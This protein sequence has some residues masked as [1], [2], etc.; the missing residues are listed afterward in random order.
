MDLPKNI[1]SGVLLFVGKTTRPFL[2]GKEFL[3]QEGHTIH[4]SEQEAKEETMNM[5]LYM[6]P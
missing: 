6:K 1:I 4:A 2:R 5:L 3:W